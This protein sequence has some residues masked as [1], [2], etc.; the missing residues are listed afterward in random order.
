MARPSLSVVIL[1]WNGRAYLEGCLDALAAQEPPPDRVV[2]VD[3]GSTDGSGGV[4]PRAVSVGGRCARTAGN[5]GF[6]AGNNVALRDETADVI[7]L[8]NP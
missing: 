1:N 3:N 7:V 5:L 4:R 2:L 8:L 6:A